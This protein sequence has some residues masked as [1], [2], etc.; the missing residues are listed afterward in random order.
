MKEECPPAAK[1]AELQEWLCELLVQMLACERV[2]LDENFFEMGA[3]SQVFMQLAAS[4][5]E[6]LGVEL[7][8]GQVLDNPTV[9]MLCAQVDTLLAEK[10]LQHSAPQ[11]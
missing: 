11:A 3:D 2:D 9:R 10:Q 7:E 6:K 4:V 8:F 1:Q 5:Y